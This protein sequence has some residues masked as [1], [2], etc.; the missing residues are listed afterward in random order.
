MVSNAR[1]QKERPPSSSASSLV[2]ASAI[3]SSS[4]SINLAEIGA[5]S[6]IDPSAAQ[7]MQRI[8][9][10]HHPIM[11][12]LADAPF[13]QGVRSGLLPRTRSEEHT[14]ELQSLIRISYAVLWLKKKSKNVF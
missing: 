9:Y 5:P 8:Y 13:A 6:I 3:A 11:Q 4:L 10:Y 2:N 1:A 12:G 14:P 7:R